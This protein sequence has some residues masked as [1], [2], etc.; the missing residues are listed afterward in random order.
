MNLTPEQYARLE[1]LF[2]EAQDLSP[3]LRVAL[4]VRVREQ[5]GAALADQLEKL[6]AV[7][8]EDTEPMFQPPVRLN[9]GQPPSALKE[10]D[11]ILKRFRIVQLLGRGGMGE[12]YA[13]QDSEIG[14]R[15]ALK[16]I[17]EDVRGDSSLLRF[18]QEVQLA[19]MVTSPYVCRIHE[20][21]TAPAESDRPAIAFLTMEFLEGE[22]LADRIAQQGPLPWRE[23]ESIALQLCEGLK[24][25]HDAGVI[26]RDFKSRNVMLT[27]RNGAV[28]PVVMDLGLAHRPELDQT[29]TNGREPLTLLG[30]VMGTP[31]YM[32]PEQFEGA[33]VSPAT[34]I[35][36]LGVVL[37]EM[38]T[39]KVPFEASTPMA[40]AVRRAKRPDSASSIRPGTPHYCDAVIEKCLQYESTQRFQSADAVAAALRRPLSL[41]MKLASRSRRLQFGIAL[42]CLTLLAAI[43]LGLKWYR[44]AT[45]HQVPAAAQRLYSQATDA[46]H[47]GSYLTATR[48]LQAALGLD[49]DFALAHAR[50]ADAFNELDSTGEAQRE[51]N[52][53]K[54]ELVSQ[55]PSREQTYIHAV[56]DTIRADASAALKDYEKLLSAADSPPERA[57]ALVDVGRTDEQAGKISEALLRYSEATSL[58]P[59]SP[60]PYLRKGILESRQ[61]KQKE[62]DA[63]FAAAEKI[64]TTNINLE[65]T[66]EVDYQ[67]SYVAS[68]L[69]AAHEQEARNFFKKS[70]DAAEKM[71]SVPL[72]VRALSRLSANEFGAAH[73]EQ[74]GKVAEDAIRL[75]EDNGVAYWATDA[76]VRLG[77]SWTY[78]DP[79]RAEEILKRARDEAERNQWPRLL[80]LSQLSLS[81]LFAQQKKPQPQ[82]E[83]INLASPAY[84]YYRVFGF[85]QESFQC[86]LMLSRATAFLGSLTESLQ[87]AT[88]A[89]ELAN[90]LASPSDQLQAEEAVGAA[91][92]WKQD[93]PAALDHLT[94]AVQMASSMGKTYKATEASLRAA[95]LLGLG[96]PSA[97]VNRALAD[98]PQ[99]SLDF[100]RLQAEI[101]MNQG[102]WKAAVRISEKAL[103]KDNAVSGRPDLQLVDAEGLTRIG[104]PSNALTLCDDV[105]QSAN[106]RS[107]VTVAQANL[108]KARA[109]FDL[110]QWQNAKPLATDAAR[111]FETS[112]QKESQLVSLWLLAKIDLAASE[113][114]EAKA[115]LQ[116]IQDILSDLRH[117]YGADNYQQFAKR[118]GIAEIL[119]DG[120]QKEV[121]SRAGS[122]SVTE[123]KVQ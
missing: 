79:K 97:E 34:D 30:T 120:S 95:A 106:D 21:F 107:P 48:Q 29:L 69:G 103:N 101:L 32:A 28:K 92:L 73:D 18:K 57:N 4:L 45:A 46:F 49:S 67:R 115:S 99:E 75:A 81:V 102:N 96:R 114:A 35:Y 13:A 76:R 8:S 59:Y 86:Q 121:R 65:G 36:A 10:G 24:A 40:A 5:E 111:F 17:R 85:A 113:P 44:S 89:A 47:N 2:T 16:T 110:S 64:Y 27:K 77:N 104:R 11:L 84:R 31:D 105:L 43:P 7:Q 39:G 78:R 15:V 60:T 109:L 122:P 118:S 91:L 53:I 19:R 82:Q 112:G 62:A 80:A 123:R 37:Y 68:K 6:L 23:A 41:R 12:V 63:D 22:T 70:L 74:A 108:V 83:V 20:F 9:G 55:L 87:H 116:K 42:A 58:D 33:R 52:K 50:L 100:A 90:R 72:R 61:G 14:R 119:S 25:I 98:I 3:A 88:E 54:E 1:Q 71:K 93:Y 38:V 66:A 56:R 51:V 117:N 26:H 94:K